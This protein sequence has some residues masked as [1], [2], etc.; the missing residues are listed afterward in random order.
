MASLNDGAQMNLEELKQDPVSALNSYC[1]LV[2]QTR[3]RMHLHERLIKQR[4]TCFSTPSEAADSDA[5]VAD[6]YDI[7]TAWY[8]SRAWLL[9]DLDDRFRVAVK[10]A[11]AQLDY[12]KDLR[13]ENI[14]PSQVDCITETLW[15]VIHNLSIT[16]GKA[17]VVS[18]TKAIHHFVPDLIPPMDVRYTGKFFW[19]HGE[20]G[21]VKRQRSI[22]RLIF[23]VFI[24]LAK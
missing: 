18:G 8:G 22:F 10:R 14:G 13:I 21:Q 20:I 4:K 9:I 17:K 24:D 11:A 3:W 2:S 19:K 5:F 12:L 7:L 15:R 23:R 6:L 16:K 1:V